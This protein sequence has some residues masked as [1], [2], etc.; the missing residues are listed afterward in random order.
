MLATLKYAFSSFYVKI[1][2]LKKKQDNVLLFKK[3]KINMLFKYI[4][5]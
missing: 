4:A 3:F 5:C 2:N 1:L